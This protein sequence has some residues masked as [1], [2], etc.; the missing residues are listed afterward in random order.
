M[1]VVTIFYYI[2]SGW[3]ATLLIVNLIKASKTKDTILYLTTLL[4]IILRLCRIN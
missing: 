3:V 1:P 2:L 4:P